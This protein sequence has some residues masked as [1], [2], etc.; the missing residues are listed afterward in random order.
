MAFFFD[1]RAFWVFVGR[2]ICF[3]M[4]KFLKNTFYLVLYIEVVKF[5]A[6]N[7]GFVIVYAFLGIK[8]PLRLIT[9]GSGTA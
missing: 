4:R 8:K 6:V 2:F 5:F 9:S 1:C 3:C 7:F